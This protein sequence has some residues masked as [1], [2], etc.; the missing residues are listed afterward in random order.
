[1]LTHQHDP[2]IQSR[3]ADELRTQ[4]EARGFQVTQSRTATEVFAGAR[5]LFGVVITFMAVM[6]VLIA[7]VG[8]LG[9]M[10][11]MS[12]NV[13]ERTREIGVMRSIGASNR[14]I[15]AIVIVEGIVIG[16]V[17]WAISILVSLPITGVLS[18]GVGMAVLNI[19]MAPSY[20]T[21]GILVWLIFTL[22]LSLV[23]SS[24]PAARASRLTVHDTLAYE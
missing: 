13:M 20:D 9:L 22:L 6:A 21:S 16:L 7:I 15:Q 14:T 24:L 4:Y 2:D 10:S 12:I 1:M 11:T 18:V 19:P 8:G 17:S 3:I 5:S 23:S